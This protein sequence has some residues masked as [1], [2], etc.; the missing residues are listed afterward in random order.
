[1]CSVKLSM[2]S[3]VPVLPPPTSI[4]ALSPSSKKN[5]A[6]G[7]KRNSAT[8]LDAT[9]TDAAGSTKTSPSK[10]DDAVQGEIDAIPDEPR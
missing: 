4:L 7:V 9:Q 1:M 6:G 10:Y 5:W 8:T 2:L 3:V